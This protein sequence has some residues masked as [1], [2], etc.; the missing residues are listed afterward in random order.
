VSADSDPVSSPFSEYADGGWK[1]AGG[2]SMGVPLWAALTA[3]ADGGRAK[4]VGLMNPALYQAGCLDSPPFNDV[5]SGDNQ[6]PSLYLPTDSNGA[7]LTGG[8][9]YRATA[10]YDLASGLGTPVVS[11]LVPDL[12]S[13]SVAC[14]AVP[15]RAHQPGDLSEFVSDGA[16]GRLW[17]AYDPSAVA[18]GSG[19]S[20]SPGA[21]VDPGDG[22]IHVFARGPQNHLLEW[23]NDRAGGRQWNAYDL[24]SAYA[25]G[26]A[27][28]AD[29]G[30]AYDAAQGILHVYAE[31][32]NGHL[33]E[34]VSD[35]AGGH[36]WNAYD[37]T[38][39]SGSP[40]V[41][42]TPS[43]VVTGSVIHVYV[44]GS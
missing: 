44:G 4:T 10:R 1:G 5:V 2:T 11:V 18:G 19:I 16:Q 36:V 25:V 15:S 21:V 39:D 38:T 26:F 33:V 14:A 35:H 20:G 12:R 9:Y 6:P 31:A 22:F 42:G 13:P 23:V 37:L 41:Q 28:A 27:L 32:S 7:P 40:G 17:N 3:L 30:P 43:S 29:R 8:P 34:Y 24:T